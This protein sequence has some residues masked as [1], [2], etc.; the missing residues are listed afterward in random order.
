MPF[1]EGNLLGFIEATFTLDEVE[2]HRLSVISFILV[3][4]KH[5]FRAL[6]KL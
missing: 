1:P 4:H 2:V 6:G 3:Y 5:S